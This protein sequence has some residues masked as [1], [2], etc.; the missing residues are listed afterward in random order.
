LASRFVWTRDT[1]TPGLHA[2]AP[3]VRAGT[4]AAVMRQ[5]PKAEGA[6]KRGAPWHDQTGNA[7]GGLNAHSEHT[8]TTDELVLAHGVDYGIW[9]E[10]AMGGTYQIVIPQIP[11]QGQELMATLGR[12]F[13][14]I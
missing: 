7:R 10:I 13:G 4:A 6:M 5:A 11:K 2:L 3:R 1:L 9:L 12:L 14:G 8:A